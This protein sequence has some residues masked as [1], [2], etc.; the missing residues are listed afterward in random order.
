MCFRIF[1]N[2]LTW[3]PMK[4]YEILWNPS[5]SLFKNPGVCFLRSAKRLRHVVR[6][7]Q[8]CKHILHT[9]FYIVLAL[10]IHFYAWW[11]MFH[12]VFTKILW[13]PMKTLVGL[14]CHWA[15][16]A[17]KCS[18]TAMQIPKQ[19]QGSVTAGRD[20]PG[21][22]RTGLDCTGL[23]WTGRGPKWSGQQLFFCFLPL[24]LC[25]PPMNN[26]HVG[27]PRGFSHWGCALIALLTYGNC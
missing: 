24:V 14:P 4:S 2:I 1:F 7:D 11:W 15:V 27:S 23:H 21:L 12:E 3:N 10:F 16:I 25:H 26:V 8:A 17:T 6:A 18:G 9:F 22:D 20:Y 5:M 13:N 19:C